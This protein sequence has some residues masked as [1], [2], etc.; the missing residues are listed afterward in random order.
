L[1]VFLDLFEQKFGV[2]DGVADEYDGCGVNVSALE[3]R[4]ED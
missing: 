4:A 3:Q 2:W 1:G